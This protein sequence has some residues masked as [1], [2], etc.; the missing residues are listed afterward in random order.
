[1]KLTEW[2]TDEPCV[3][4]SGNLGY[5]TA[6]RVEVTL[7]PGYGVDLIDRN[8]N[9]VHRWPVNEGPDAVE[10]VGEH[11]CRETACDWIVARR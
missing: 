5:L 1:M 4:D 6:Y 3:F 7:P 11:Q 9:V 2:L 8:D 10:F